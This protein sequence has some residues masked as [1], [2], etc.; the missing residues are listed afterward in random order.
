MQQA[1]LRV[2]IAGGGTGGHLFPGLAVARELTARQPGARVTFAG[3]AQGIES[4]L[5]PREGFELDLIRS[6]GL[7]GKS[8]T[9]LA[10]GLAL[11]PLGLIDAARV[12]ARTRPS[13]VVG[14]GGY[15][16]G[17]VVML[18]GGALGLLMRP[19]R[20]PRRE[21]NFSSCNLSRPSFIFASKS[22]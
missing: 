21:A 11:L 5:I 15:S 19:M 12:I 17:P 18:V 2:V 14:V 6:A 8:L 4:R 9:A 3:T 1:E 10:R 13:V 22:L 7:K 16:S 20:L